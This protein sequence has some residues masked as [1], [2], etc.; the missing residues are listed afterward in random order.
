MRY[1]ELLVAEEMGEQRSSMQWV[2]FSSGVDE[3]KIKEIRG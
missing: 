1:E 2:S 3:A